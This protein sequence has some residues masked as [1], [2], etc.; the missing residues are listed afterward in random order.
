MIFKAAKRVPGSE[1]H[2]AF[3]PVLIWRGRRKFELELEK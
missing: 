3:D 2:G 1:Q